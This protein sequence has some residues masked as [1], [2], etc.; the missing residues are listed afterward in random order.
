MTKTLSVVIP[1]FNEEEN[2]EAAICDVTAAIS[3]GGD[4]EIIVVDDGSTDRTALL[5]RSQAVKN[6]NIKVLVNETNRGF[7]YSFKRGVA[8]ATKDFVTGF[9]GDNDMSAGCLRQLLN[10]IGSEDLVISYMVSQG[11]RRLVRRLLSRGF[12]TLLNGLFGLN[13]AYYNG[14]FL[15]RRS[16]IQSLPIKSDGLGMV[17]ECLVRLIK[18]GCRYKAIPFEHTGRKH[19]QSKALRLKSILSVLY[20]VSIL[21]KDVY[22]TSSPVRQKI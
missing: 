20:T 13:L 1:A 17:A 12:V 4:Y 14:A 5:A 3:A 19:Q 9:P 11:N 21:L 10:Q 2:I 16:L 22:F 7:G 15:C 8:A 6:P 18:A